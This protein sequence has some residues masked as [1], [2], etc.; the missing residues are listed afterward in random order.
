MGGERGDAPPF[1]VDLR[2]VLK[3]WRELRRRLELRHGVEFLE[4]R[5]EGVRETPLGARRKLVVLGVE[6]EV[7]DAAGEVLRRFEFSFHEGAVNHELHLVVPDLALF[8]DFDLPAHR[9]EI[10]LHA[11]DA[12]RDRVNEAETLRMLR[13]HRAEISLE[14]HVVANEDAVAYGH[15]EAHR[16]VV[17]VA[18]ANRE[19]AALE[20]GFEIEDAEH[21]HAVLGDR[22]FV[23]HDGDVPECER[24]EERL[25]DRMVC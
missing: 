23:A 22:V 16:L 13:E 11:V 5:R 1:D 9:L 24:F 3:E 7:V 6:I 19:P 18:D 21:L 4:R 15:R 12:D 14:R 20:G 8:P 17:R 10:T 25:D 2:V